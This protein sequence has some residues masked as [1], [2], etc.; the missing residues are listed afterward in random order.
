M[1]SILQFMLSILVKLSLPLQNRLQLLQVI[2]P[3]GLVKKK[4]IMLLD[5]IIWE[6][7]VGMNKKDGEIKEVAMKDGEEMVE[8]TTD[9]EIPEAKEEIITVG[10]IKE[11]VEIIMD[12]EI[13]AEEVE[14]IM[15][16]D[17]AGD[18]IDYHNI[19]AFIKCDLYLK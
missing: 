2:K 18:S 15:G 7:L 12:G 10:E 1:M 13:K 16:G 9:G 11:E 19:N 8:I 6:L 4:E 14:I 5:G 3:A 17:Q